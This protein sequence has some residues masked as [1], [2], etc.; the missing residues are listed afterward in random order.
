MNDYPIGF[1]HMGICGKSNLGNSG[2]RCHE[3]ALQ[4]QDTVGAE[5]AIPN[6][7][8]AGLENR[9]GISRLQR[10]KINRPHPPPE[11]VPDS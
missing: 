8:C 9:Q 3:P 5:P 7:E 11:A 6:R 10:G 1:L 2:F 4:W